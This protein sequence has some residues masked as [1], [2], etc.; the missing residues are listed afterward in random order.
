M[1]GSSGPRRRREEQRAQL[2][3]P[4]GSAEAVL[5][6]VPMQVPIE[7]PHHA[8]PLLTSDAV[9]LSAP[10][11]ENFVGAGNLAPG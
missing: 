5:G 10:P 6:D 4:S 8:R 3:K 7:F 2:P 9:V 1:A 11:H